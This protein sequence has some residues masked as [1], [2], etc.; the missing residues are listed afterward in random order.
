MMSVKL[1][2]ANRLTVPVLSQVRQAVVVQAA[3]EYHPKRAVAL[4]VQVAPAHR[5]NAVLKI[6]LLA[7]LESRIAP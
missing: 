1:A 4:A 7:P 3:Q 2:E 6:L 5:L